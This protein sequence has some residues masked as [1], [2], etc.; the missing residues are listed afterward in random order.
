VRSLEEVEAGVEQ[1]DVAAELVDHEAADE[2]PLGRR[3][4]LHVT[5]QRRE[6]AA[7]VDVADQQHRANL[8]VKRDLHVDD[9][10]SLRLISAEL[11]APSTTTRSL[12]ARSRWPARR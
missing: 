3:E 9:V 1:A 2:G 7:P 12:A 11:P 4:E 5:D 8:G 6:H 10:W